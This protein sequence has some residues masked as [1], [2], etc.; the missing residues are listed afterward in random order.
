MLAAALTATHFGPLVICVVAALVIGTFGVLVVR[1]LRQGR[2]RSCELI[3]GPLQYR[4]APPV[5][6]ESGD[7][8]R[9]LRRSPAQRPS[10][11]ARDSRR[12]SVAKATRSARGRSP[13]RVG[14]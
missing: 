13:V 2:D 4:Q 12:E 1:I 10:R 11:S 6:P 8:R 5:P 14:R 7:E 9:R 3:I